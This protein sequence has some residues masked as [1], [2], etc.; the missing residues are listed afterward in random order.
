MSLFRKN[1]GLSNQTS[2]VKKEFLLD[3]EQIEA[4]KSSCHHIVVI[5]GAGSGKTRVLTERV[6]HLLKEDIKA[7]N[8]VAITFTN[9]A[10]EEMKE[11]L[12]DVKGVADT[13]IGTIHS[14]A[15]KIMKSSGEKY[16]L[17][18]DDVDFDFHRELISRYCKDLTYERY[19]D[20]RDIVYKVDTGRLPSSAIA[21]FL[22]IPE[23]S[24]IYLMHRDSESVFV[25]NFEDFPESIATLCRQRGIITFDELL[26]R[27][28]IYF[29]STGAFVEHLLVD[30]FQDV[31]T[32]EY[33]FIAG[34]SATN[35]FF[36]GD[37]RQSIYGFKGSNVKIFQ[38]LVMSENVKTYYLKNNYRNGTRIF[39]LADLVISQVTNK[40]DIPPTKTVDYSGEVV[41]MRRK[42]L[43]K[44]IMKITNFKNQFI[45]TRT[46]RELFQVANLCEKLG[47]P[48]TTFKR[49]GMSLFEL[50]HHLN[51]D[52]V[53]ILT[54]HSAK[55]L[56]ADNVILYGS[57]P[58]VCPR[59]QVNEEERRIM[60]VGIT[61]A[62][63][64]LVL[65]N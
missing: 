46:N 51:K 60:Y 27:A 39:E 64:M 61:R 28:K 8:I 29:E 24:E 42:D 58:V 56:E 55:G 37:D 3:R 35:T 63:H 30:E 19:I 10:A 5:A 45:L 13:F 12:E 59:Y 32:L 49:E 16:S 43:E 20:Y 26:V 34:L 47:V 9:L 33:K 44:A 65:L 17:F 62:R 1:R 38:N 52:S 22:T 50:K 21:G 54:V 48:C 23:Q 25:D 2:F 31:G 18:T 41:F 36:V 4:V 6:K 40:L 57:F 14:F 11:R 15:N 7:S 53:K